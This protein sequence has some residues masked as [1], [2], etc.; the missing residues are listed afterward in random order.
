MAGRGRARAP[1][2]L[3]PLVIGLACTADSGGDFVPSAYWEDPAVF[4]VGRE[5]P[6]ASFTAFAS[7]SEALDGRPGESSFRLN[8]NGDWKF[9]WSPTP[10]GR[11]AD[12]FEPGFDASAWDDIPVPGNW[13]L[14]GYGY[15]VYRDESYSFPADPPRIPPGDNP[16]GSYLRT[17]ELPADWEGREVFL[18]FDGVYSAFFVWLNGELLGYSEGSRTPAEFRVT[19]VARPGPNAVAVQVYRWSDGSYLESQDFWR[20]SGIDRD[21]YL[22]S[23][24]ATFLRDF[25]VQADLEAGSGDGLLD[26]TVFLATQGPASLREVVYELL[27]PEGNPVWSERR[28]LTVEVP[29]SGEATATVTARVERPLPWTAETPALY[30]LVLS[31]AGPGGEVTEVISTRVGFRRVQITDGI[32]TVNGQPI[33]LRGVNR[34][35][36]DPDRGHV[37]DEAMMIEDIRLM[38]QFNIN[39]VR[40]AHYPNV[41]RWY[42]LTDEYGLYVVDEA[43]IESHGMG[44]EPGVTL[45]GRPEWRAAHLDRT[46][47]MVERDKNHA[48][49]IIW[50]LGN[51]AGDGENFDST[52]AWIRERDPSRPI[53]YEPSGERDNIDIVAP[54]YVRPYWLERYAAS[55]IA[56][57]FVLVEYAHAMGNSVGNLADYWTV[58]DEH[59]RLQGGFIWDWVDQSLRAR[60]EQGTPY[61]AYGG[62]FGP[63]GVVTDGNFLVNGLVSADRKPHP[64]AWEV[65]K[66]YQPVRVSEIDLAGGRLRVENRRDF[67]DLSDLAGHW[68]LLADG[69][70]TRSGRLPALSTPPGQADTLSLNLPVVDPRPGVEYLL[71]VRFQN[72]VATRSIPAGHEVARDQFS[73]P[74]RRPAVPEPPRQAWLEVVD[75]DDALTVAGSGAT[76]RFDRTLGTLAAMSV[77]GREVLRSGPVPNFWRAP[78]DNDYG[79]GLPIRSGVWRRAGQPPARHLDSMSVETVPFDYWAEADPPAGAGAGPVL[80]PRPG[81]A[82]HVRV[83]SYYTIR[84]VGARYVLVHDVFRDGTIAVS[85]RLSAVDEDLPEMPRFGTIMTLAGAFDRVEWYGRGPFENYWDRRTGASVGRYVSRAGDLAHPYVRPQETGTRSDTR[86]AA[87]RDAAGRGLLVTGLPTVSFSALPYRMRDLDSGERKSRRH[88]SDME[89]RDEVTLHVDY[90][91]TGVGGDDSWGAVPHREYTIWPQDMEFRFLLR[92]LRPG[93]DPAEVARTALPDSAAVAS[94]ALRSL[95]LDDFGERNRAAHLARGRPVRVEPAASSPYSAAGDA[96]LVDGIRG[97]IDRRGGHWQGYRAETVTARIDLDGVQAVESVK[98][99]F[100]QHPGSGV[101][102]PRRVEVAVSED[103]VTFGDPVVQAVAQDGPPQHARRYVTVLTGSAQAR[104]VRVRIHGA[105]EVPAGWAHAG[106]MAW[107][108]A[109]EVIVR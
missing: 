60:D 39:A 64:H 107:V 55:G 102:F 32:L 105:G 56:K 19:E 54:M 58:I 88:W 34:H 20:I 17:F 74:V 46:R 73:L 75:Q 78:T 86:W 27:D 79:N 61:W 23:T 72:R 38:K 65:K 37:V 26:L 94:V 43:N 48:S 28:A 84:S 92:P 109:D 5:P 33:V 22:V 30:R 47:R 11:A 100:L 87:L 96:G 7:R 13:E 1:L 4:A 70:V 29:D 52:A 93:E 15:P 45:A 99:G 59:P 69:Q 106:Q 76:L 53:L 103:G 51:E 21:V 83:T 101:Y 85:A 108:Y 12:F 68:E 8:L 97:S 2:W 36:H 81:S 16:V 14:E 44:S 9:H 3:T 57:P 104:A 90:R 89:P 41:P 67:T 42:E 31:H 35:E 49:V 25:H 66:V 80:P 10:D 63:A 40:T 98:V 77:Q 91:Q 82:S 24:P 62:D 95:L 18:H 71:N 6:R 50:S